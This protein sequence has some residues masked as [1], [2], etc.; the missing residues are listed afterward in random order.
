[1]ARFD[2]FFSHPD[3]QVVP[4]TPAVFDRAAQIRATHGYKTLDAI[5]LAAAAEANCDLFLTNDTQLSGFADITVE[6]LH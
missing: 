1:L 3:V 5:N 6:I 4:I 2:G